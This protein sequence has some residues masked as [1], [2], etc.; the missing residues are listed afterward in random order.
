MRLATPIRKPKKNR[1]LG[2]DIFSSKNYGQSESV[3]DPYGKPSCLLMTYLHHRKVGLLMGAI[4]CIYSI[5]YLFGWLH[6][7]CGRIFFI[8]GSQRSRQAIQWV[9][10]G[11]RW[12]FRLGVKIIL[13]AAVLVDVNLQYLKDLN[14]KLLFRR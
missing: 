7:K 14:W 13:A 10:E 5:K 6:Q 4:F 9:R 11:Q 2:M 1:Q 3:L 8:P 12:P